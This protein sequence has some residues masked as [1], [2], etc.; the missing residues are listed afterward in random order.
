[1]EDGDNRKIKY[2]PVHWGLFLAVCI[3]KTSKL[4][5]VSTTYFIEHCSL[6][7]TSEPSDPGGD[8]DMLIIFVS[9]IRDFLAKKRLRY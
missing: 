6:G 3:C 4:Q 8:T 1:M 9:H 2:I 5:L 7:L